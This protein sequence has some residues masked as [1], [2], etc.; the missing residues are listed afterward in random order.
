VHD[1]SDRALAKDRWDV[2]ILRKHHCTKNGLS[3]FFVNTCVAYLKKLHTH[4]YAFATCNTK[5]TSCIINIER[6]KI[7]SRFFSLYMSHVGE[8]Q[9]TAFPFQ[10]AETDCDREDSPAMQSLC[11][12]HACCSNRAMKSQVAVD[13][14]H[15]S[16]GLQRVKCGVKTCQK[17]NQKN[18]I[19]YAFVPKQI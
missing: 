1:T 5:K 10:N 12:H 17:G 14:R 9:F 19:S 11:I 2:A 4:M 13:V 8:R 6:G 7:F 15:I 3:R 16:F 18:Q